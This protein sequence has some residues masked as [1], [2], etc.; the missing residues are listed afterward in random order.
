MVQILLLATLPVGTISLW[1]SIFKQRVSVLARRWLMQLGK[2]L[3]VKCDEVSQNTGANEACTNSSSILF[4]HSSGSFA[5]LFCYRF[6]QQKLISGR[7]HAN[8]KKSHLKSIFHLGIC[9]IPLFYA[10][11][12]SWPCSVFLEDFSEVPL[13]PCLWSRLFAETSEEEE[14]SALHSSSL[15][16]SKSAGCPALQS[17]HRRSSD[18]KHGQHTCIQNTHSH[19]VLTLSFFPPTVRCIISQRI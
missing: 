5:R 17:M 11:K 1:P 16:E 18:V 9:W 10:V 8:R 12:T 15:G 7:N 13:P 2:E 14:A 3:G 6:F 4:N 19:T